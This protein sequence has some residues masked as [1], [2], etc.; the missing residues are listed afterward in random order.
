VRAQIF[1]LDAFTHRRFAGNPAAVVPLDRF[2][3]DAVLRA[4][5]IEN[6]L[7]ATAFIVR[8][9][10]NYAIRWF[11]PTEEIE[12]CGHATL[13]SAAVVL[14]RL[15]PGRRHVGFRSSS[16]PFEVSREDSGYRMGLP[17]RACARLVHAPG[18]A[19]ALG[20]SPYEVWANEFSAVAVFE[21]AAAVRSLE[22]STIA[23]SHL[24]WPAV[25]VTAP[26][27]NG[28]D[29][30]S[31][32]FA[33]KKGIAEDPVTGAAHCTLAPYWTSRLGV[34]EFRAYQA[35]RRGGE[36]VCRIVDDRVELES[37]CIFFLEGEITI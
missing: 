15:E 17:A 31:R 24:E 22:P 27:D 12:L 33:P 5:A 37:N 9:D 2:L 8:E 26:G 3:E 28:F 10:E 25:I 14:D 6:N 7:P 20:A 30:V 4:V 32:Y 19:D 11:T 23:L 35:S 13:A 16:G 1:Q 36:M 18:L 34:S 21:N 29:I